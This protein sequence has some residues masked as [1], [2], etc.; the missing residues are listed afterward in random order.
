M[1]LLIQATTTKIVS[2]IH[3]QRNRWFGNC[4]VLVFDFDASFFRFFCFECVPKFSSKFV[5]MIFWIDKMTFIGFISGYFIL[6]T[7]NGGGNK[8]SIH[9]N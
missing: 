4:F 7:T 9:L 3:V 8:I 2:F 6:T 5:W 1:E